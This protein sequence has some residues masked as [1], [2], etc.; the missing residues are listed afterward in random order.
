[1][2]NIGTITKNN[3]ELDYSIALSSIFN[4]ISQEN[5]NLISEQYIAIWSRIIIVS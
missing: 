5:N 1:M 4:T 2:L 3:I